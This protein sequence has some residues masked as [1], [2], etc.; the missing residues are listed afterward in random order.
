[1]ARWM[2]GESLLSGK[3]LPSLRM[4]LPSELTFPKWSE[5]DVDDDNGEG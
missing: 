1:V 5:S 4:Q 3:A 2:S